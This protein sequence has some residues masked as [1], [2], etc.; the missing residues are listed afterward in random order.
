M[1]TLMFSGYAVGGM[2]AALLGK[3]LI[4]TYGW[5]SVFLAAGAAGA[6]DPVHPEVA[7]PSRC[8]SCSSRAATTS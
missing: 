6:A 8:R 7:C 1:V 2:L 5:S 3:G 4:E